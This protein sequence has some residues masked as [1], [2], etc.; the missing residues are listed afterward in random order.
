[1]E[2]EPQ[3][4]VYDT[5]VWSPSALERFLDWATGARYMAYSAP[6][7]R[8]RRLSW[9]RTPERARQKGLK[10]LRKSGGGRNK[11]TRVL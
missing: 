6:W 5:T 9:G 4:Y 8:G 10:E 1:M 11:P 3:V 7:P 2:D